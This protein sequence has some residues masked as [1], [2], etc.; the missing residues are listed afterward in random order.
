MDR[1]FYVKTVTCTRRELNL[2]IERGLLVQT[3]VG[4]YDPKLMEIVSVKLND[5]R[6]GETW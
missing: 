4:Y 2:W 1:P 3:R 5:W 6:T